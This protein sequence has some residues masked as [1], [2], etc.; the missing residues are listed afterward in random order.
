MEFDILERFSEDLISY[1]R[2]RLNNSSIQ[3]NGKLDQAE[4]A[5]KLYTS[6]DKYEYMIRQNPALK[7]LKDRLGLDFD[8]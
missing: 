3:V 6:K 1:L 4:K 2:T 8:V 7:E 5:K